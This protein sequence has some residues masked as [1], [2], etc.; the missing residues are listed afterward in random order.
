VK[1]QNRIIHAFFDYVGVVNFALGKDIVG[2][3]LKVMPD[4]F[5]NH[6]LADEDRNDSAQRW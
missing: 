5:A 1:P 4:R 6:G 2:K 3:L